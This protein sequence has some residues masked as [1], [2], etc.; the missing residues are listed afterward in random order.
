M[1]DGDGSR[2]SPLGPDKTHNFAN[3][4]SDSV[5]PKFVFLLSA[6][7]QDGRLRQQSAVRIG[8]AVRGWLCRLRL[9]RELRTEFDGERRRMPD[10]GGGGG[11]GGR[12]LGRMVEMI[13]LMYGRG[14]DDAERLVRHSRRWR[15]TSEMLLGHEVMTTV[16][17]GLRER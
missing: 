17:P 8:A 15:R 12:R 10:G 4:V 7:V 11:D 14:G 16:Q 5:T 6:S 13:L 1:G 3:E 2:S 9:A